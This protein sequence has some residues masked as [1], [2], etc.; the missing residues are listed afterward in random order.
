[1][2]WYALQV[3]T[4][5][6]FEIAEVIYK[7]ANFKNLADKITDIFSGVKKIV[8]MTSKGRRID[9]EPVLNGYIFVKLLQD[10]T[11]EIWHL[12]KNVPGVFKVLDMLPISEEEIE[13]LQ[14]KCVGEIEFKI[15]V[16]D[17]TELDKQE[18]ITTVIDENEEAHLCS[19]TTLNEVRNDLNGTDAS[20]KLEVNKKQRFS[21]KG[22]S[23]PYSYIKTLMYSFI[24]GG[25]K[26]F[27]IPLPVY[28]EILEAD[29]LLENP[30]NERNPYFI[31]WVA[32]R[33]FR[34][35]LM[36]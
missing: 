22:E 26:V 20:D 29:E 24:K 25:K 4:G 13:H 7:Y 31:L 35:L 12:L 9:A 27:R 34:K 21:Q 6:E 10:M 19:D 33:H 23:T 2:S 18:H 15:E 3:K 8:K 36:T 30:Q 14:K 1:M 32:K 16:K 5:Q 28:R 11:G 17:E